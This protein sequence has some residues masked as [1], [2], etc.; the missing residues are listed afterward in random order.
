MPPHSQRR[1]RPDCWL[2]CFDG[3]PSRRPIGNQHCPAQAPIFAQEFR[4]APTKYF[5]AGAIALFRREY[6]IITAFM[7]RVTDMGRNEL[8]C[9]RNAEHWEFQQKSPRFPFAANI[10]CY[11]MVTWA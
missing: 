6:S 9:Q 1:F 3:P 5:D 4:T 11:I 2:R 8:C 7:L 10:A